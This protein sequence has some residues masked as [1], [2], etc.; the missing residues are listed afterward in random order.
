MTLS[1]AISS[2]LPEAC[3]QQPVKPMI[4]GGV[5]AVAAD[6]VRGSPSLN[7][8]EARLHLLDEA[9]VRLQA[10]RRAASP[11]STSRISISSSTS[12]SVG[13]AR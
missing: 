10:A 5:F 3:D 13:I 1:F 7:A 6:L 12:G 4:G 9:P 11:S 2:V 8:G